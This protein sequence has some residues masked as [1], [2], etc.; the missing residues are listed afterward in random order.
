LASE[1][2]AIARIQIG[3]FGG[4]NGGSRFFL[5]GGETGLLRFFILDA[6]NGNTRLLL[7]LT[8]AD[9]HH[10]IIIFFAE[11]FDSFGSERGITV[12]TMELAKVLFNEVEVV[13]P[14][15]I[16]SCMDGR[17]WTTPKPYLPF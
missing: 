14:V 8:T 10:P 7:T 9:F 12:S 1:T 6:D 2:L 15:R 3:A 16:L 13:H 5:N 17:R 11:E 4:Q